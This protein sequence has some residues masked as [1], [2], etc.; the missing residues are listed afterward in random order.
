MK[1]K[2]NIS[3]GKNKRY[4]TSQRWKEESKAG[5]TPKAKKWQKKDQKPQTRDQEENQGNLGH[6]C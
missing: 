2:G 5:G 6:L 4:L 3:R 1:T